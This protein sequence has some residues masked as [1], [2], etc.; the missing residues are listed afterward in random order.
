M[1][2]ETKFFNARNLQ[3]LALFLVFLGCLFLSDEG[4]K[5]LIYNGSELKSDATENATTFY[6]PKFLFNKGSY[7]INIALND[8]SETLPKIELWRQ[9]EKLTEWQIA[10]N[11]DNFSSDFT[12]PYDSQDVQFRVFFDSE[13]NSNIT[14]LTI[15]PKTFFYSDTYF[16]IALFLLAAIF[17]QLYFAKNKLT[18]QQIIDLCLILGIAVLCTFPFF[19]TTNIYDKVDIGYHLT[20]IEG[21]KDGILDG[22]MGAYILPQ[23]AEN[24]G[25]LNALYPYSFL[26]IPALL[27]LCKVSLL[28]SYKFFILLINLA[29]ALSVYKASK[30]ITKSRLNIFLA[31]ILYVFMPFRLNNLF[32][33][34]ALGEVLAII[35]WPMV[36]AGLYNTVFGDKRKWYYLAIG[37]SGMIQSHILSAMLSVVFC[38]LA[39]FLFIKQILQSK[40]YLQIIKV[41]FI[42]A[43]LNIFF[44]IPFLYYYTKADINCSLEILDI[45]NYFEMSIN[46]SNFLLTFIANSDFD[47]RYSSIGL[48]YFFVIAICLVYLFV[49]KNESKKTGHLFFSFLFILGIFIAFSITQYFPNR[50]LSQKFPLLNKF[51]MSIQFPFRLFIPVCAFLTFAFIYSFENSQIIKKYKNSICVIICVFSLLPLISFAVKGEQFP[52]QNNLAIATKSHNQKLTPPM[53]YVFEYDNF[54]F[55]CAYDIAKRTDAISTTFSPYPIPSL[56]ENV[57]ISNFSKRGTKLSFDY[58]ASGDDLTV[59]V[60]LQW[61]SGYKAFNENR[62]PLPIAKSDLGKIQLPLAGD[63]TEHKIFVQYGS[64]PLFIAANIISAIS[65]C[66]LAILL[67]CKKKKTEKILPKQ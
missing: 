57:K 48:H 53:F 61:Y 47:F 40:A 14:K 58:T 3:F 46:P 24:Y 42:T 10:Q 18:Q 51:F 32:V 25:Y 28:F 62:Q 11:S 49:E 55:A 59:E 26:Y 17:A 1:K 20:R 4:R 36:I 15:S 35:F 44:I 64:I 39:A 34:S 23:G 5:P 21:I 19:G 45:T 7:N 67:V 65:L 2:S 41:I 12:L 13:E 9:S 54:E 31:M 37:I 29:T 6:T 52:Y 16:M 56:A 27:R 38:I 43:L 50:F 63:G 22:Q 8:V 33:R 66:V 30:T 60:P